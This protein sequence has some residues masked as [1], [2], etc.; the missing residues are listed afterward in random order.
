MRPPLQP[1]RGHGHGHGHGPG[2]GPGHGH[3]RHGG[4]PGVR[5]WIGDRLHRQLFATIAVSIVLS[6]ATVVGVYRLLGE[7]HGSWQRSVERVQRVIARRLAA[8]WHD[9]A[10]RAADVRDLS[11]AIGGGIVV[12]DTD[13]TTLHSVGWD[14]RCHWDS[15]LTI[16]GPS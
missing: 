2:H 7:G 5:G 16:E 13:G 12:A 15:A 11:E 9:P 14:E 6:V 10:A 3:G 4:R 1:H 8:D